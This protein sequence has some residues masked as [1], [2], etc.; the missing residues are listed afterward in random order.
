MKII[1]ASLSPNTDS[2]DVLTALGVLMT[3]WRWNNGSA[4]HVVSQWFEKR[5]GVVPVLFNSGRSALLGILKAYDI[6]K[7]DEVLVQAFTCVAVPNSVLWNGATP[8]YVD[9]DDRLN[10][11]PADI[12]KKV[13]KKTKAIVVQHTLGIPAQIDKI[14][15][16]AK[17]HDLLVIED[18]A[19]ALGATY[20]GKALGTWGD[21][22]FFSFGRDKVVSSVFGGAAIIRGSRFKIEDVRLKQ[23]QEKLEFPSMFWIMQ[24]VLHPIVFAVVLPL[25]RIGIGKIIL[26]IFQR[27]K[28]LSFPVY[29]E[30]KKGKRPADFPKKYPNAL[31][32]MLVPQL[33]KLDRLV[34]LRQ[35]NAHVYHEAFTKKT[36]RVTPWVEGAG[37]L[38]FPF[39]ADNPDT[40][41]ARAKKKGVLLGNWYTNVIDP[42]GVDFDAIGYIPGSCPQAEEASTYIV[43]MPTT[44]R[45]SERDY[46]LSVV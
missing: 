19:H 25:Y 27:L 7:G 31:A 14:I 17:K 35:K 4:Q 33:A 28:L 10:M 43:N 16:V 26:M 44:L 20:K 2:R 42:V 8:V 23:Y 38:R 32:Q 46:T 5:F 34:A 9:I 3:P 39:F 36:Y 30:E 29:T 21:A 18:C 24:Q 40:L 41:R 22:A 45:V 15:Q 6:A 1:S 11:D 12:G 37:Y 13:T